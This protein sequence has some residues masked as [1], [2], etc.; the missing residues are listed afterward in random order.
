MKNTLKNTQSKISNLVTFI[1]EFF[2]AYRIFAEELG[3][4]EAEF[5]SRKKYKLSPLGSL[6]DNS[7]KFMSLT[8]DGYTIKLKSV[9]ENAI[10]KKQE[11]DQAFEKLKGMLD[12]LLISLKGLEQLYDNEYAPNVE[13]LKKIQREIKN[14]EEK[15]ENTLNDPLE[16][17]VISI[18]ERNKK[19]LNKLTSLEQTVK[20]KLNSTVRMINIELEK[21]NPFLIDLSFACVETLSKNMKTFWGILFLVTIVDNTQMVNRINSLSD[22]VQ[23]VLKL[24]KEDLKYEAGNINLITEENSELSGFLLKFIQKFNVNTDNIYSKLDSY[25]AEYDK[26]EAQLPI[27]NEWK[28]QL[29]NYIKG[30]I[31]FQ[32][33]LCLHIGVVLKSKLELAFEGLTNNKNE[34]KRNPNISLLKDKDLEIFKQIGD[35][36]NGLLQYLFSTLNQSYVET[37]EYVKLL[38]AASADSP[39]L[40]NLVKLEPLT[41]L[42]PQD[43]SVST[44]NGDLEESKALPKME[45]P[46]FMFKTFKVNEPVV[47][48]YLCA[49][50]WKLILQGRLYLTKSYLCFYSGFNKDTLFG[51][52]TKVCIPLW[53]IIE[54]KKA[55]NALIFDNSIIVKTKNADFFF[56]SFLS[57]D[58]A[59]NLLKILHENIEKPK[60]ESKEFSVPRLLDKSKEST[61]IEEVKKEQGEDPILQKLKE[62]EKERLEKAKKDL[63]L[64][65]P[66]SKPFLDDIYPC[67]IQLLL[68]AIIDRSNSTFLKIFKE[69]GNVDLVIEEMTPIPEYYMKFKYS[70]NELLKQSKEVKDEFIE[71]ALKWSLTGKSKAKYTHNLTRGVPIPFFPK[72]FSMKE[73]ATIYYISPNYLI[74]LTRIDEKGFPYDDHVFTYQWMEVT[75]IVE[76]GECKTK[77]RMYAENIFVKRTVFLNI[78][79]KAAKDTIVSTIN[80]ITQPLYKEHVKKQLINYK[81]FLESKGS[82]ISPWIPK[83]NE[84]VVEDVVLKEFKK[85]AMYVKSINQILQNQRRMYMS[86]FIISIILGAL[87]IIC[88]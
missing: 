11:I 86:I 80:T 52:E 10:G 48:S 23:A 26:N 74:M 84:S 81:K 37:E 71:K 9:M 38:K 68:P 33:K 32:K 66:T 56:T 85:N 73:D 78:I 46:N 67:P 40:Q 62:M 72:Q 69:T 22:E 76:D 63:G 88:K 1:L 39:D 57:R 12:K 2:K 77:L 25:I 8:K 34:L 16:Q 19:S 47:E 44:F 35:S 75:Q 64:I 13:T 59:Y 36:I 5:I 49:L 6:V 4:F 18:K 27:L 15:Y 51:K 30:K 43:V 14:I 20:H 82:D 54:I 7:V 24:T 70:L 53:D 45:E 60:P 42:S 21:F 28:E 3:S 17:Y 79:D 29:K 41:L 55:H 83:L 87:I 31:T 61:F 65:M 50:Q 58:N